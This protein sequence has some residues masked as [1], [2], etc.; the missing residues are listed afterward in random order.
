MQKGEDIG[1]RIT[2]KVAMVAFETN[3]PGLVSHD[4]SQLQSGSG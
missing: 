4:S 2:K 1:L 3:F